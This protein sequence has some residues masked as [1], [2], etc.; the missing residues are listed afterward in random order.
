M[1]SALLLFTILFWLCHLQLDVSLFILLMIAA[2]GYFWI[3]FRKP[4]LALLIVL[5][6]CLRTF[7]LPDPYQEYAKIEK[8]LSEK[9]FM[10]TEIH[11]GYKIA[12]HGSF[13]IVVYDEEN[14]LGIHDLLSVRELEEIYSLNNFHLYS[15]ASA[16]KNRR[17]VFSTDNY[18]IIEQGST[19]AAKIY[20]FFLQ[21]PDLAVC[22]LLAG[23][24]IF[25]DQKPSWAASL[26]LPFMGL[27]SLLRAL[28]HRRISRNVLD[29]LVACICFIWG[30]FFAWPPALIR[31][32]VCLVV[33]SCIKDK[34]VAWSLSV[35]IYLFLVPA[36][37]FQLCF[38]FQPCYLLALYGPEKY[39]PKRLSVL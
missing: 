33:K 26:G 12:A 5:V 18:Q 31:V 30:Y 7:S 35:L 32:L 17:I 14:Q 36:Y 29:F 10:V 34:K 21:D 1:K 37:A 2:G 16:M 28:F 27:V 13:E 22:G 25:P 11:Q 9:V 4:V 15:F 19:P 6:C 20:R 3:R 8:N 24:G 23:Y 38:Y 39:R